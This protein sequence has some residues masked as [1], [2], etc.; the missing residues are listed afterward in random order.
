MNLIIVMF[1][2][3][4]LFW[5]SYHWALYRLAKSLGMIRSVTDLFTSKEVTKLIIGILTNSADIKLTKL[6]YY[7][8][9]K[10]HLFAFPVFLI[11]WWI[12]A[13]QPI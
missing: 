7:K 10:L 3:C 1:V 13:S 12:I 11:A 8:L 9:V 4:V 6:R 5:L 2:L